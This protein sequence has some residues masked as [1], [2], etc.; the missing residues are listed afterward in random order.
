MNA[1]PNCGAGLRFDPAKQRLVCD[2]CDSEFDPKEIDGTF[3]AEETTVTEEVPVH[4]EEPEFETYET[5]VYTCPQCGGE[6][7]SDANTVATFCSF[8]GA[9]TVL[10]SRIRKEKKPAY[11]IP[12]VKT[13]EEC[14]SLYRK[15]VSRS[16]FA[17]AYMQ[18]PETVD[19]FRGIYMPYWVYGFNFKG[20]VN[21][22]ATKSHRRGDYIYTSHFD[23]SSNAEAEFKG[24]AYDAS[25]SFSDSLSEAIAPFDTSK[26]VPFAPT[27]LSGFYGDTSDVDAGVYSNEA[28]EVMSA[29]AADQVLR[30]PE[31]RGYSIDG[32]KVKNQVIG[33][34][35]MTQEL[36]MFP[37][38]F[39][40]VRNKDRVSY[41]VVNG[42]TGKV[43]V[44]IPI[45]FK[46]YLLG[47]AILA[48]PLF[49]L[50][51][52]FFTIKPEFMLGIAIALALVSMLIS[53]SQIN[54]VYARENY[55]D[56]KGWNSVGGGDDTIRNREK[57]EREGAVVTQKIDSTRI[58]TKQAK[59]GIGTAIWIICFIIS[60]FFSPVLSIVIAIIWGAVGKNSNN[61]TRAEVKQ[62]K[63]SAKAP[64]AEKWKVLWKPLAGI[65]V[66]LGIIICL[67]AEDLWFYAAAFGCMI[68]VGLSFLDLVKEHN[69]LTTRKLPQFNKR[70]GDAY[71][72]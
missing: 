49:L 34:G 71:E 30:S 50:F 25:S 20:R 54:R 39:L 62:V 41:A 19:R 63:V 12:F 47:S 68:L 16:I 53:N 65:V 57:M 64:G 23:I 35:K 66:S 22:D 31:Y 18:K 48:V 51:N 6:L 58:K 7:L 15:A 46:K 9:S 2:F 8:C 17:P 26:T 43:A 33:S 40:A 5:T 36:G 1:C 37:V 60:L 27:Y 70:G 44:D 13:Q 32:N 24:I 14:E 69:R 56:D 4:P 28:R 52:L 3:T 10:E 72:E 11:I 55:L 67:P 29:N 21:T 61:V 42:Q 59:D 45:D 38:W